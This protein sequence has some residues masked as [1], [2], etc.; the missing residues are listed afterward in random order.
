MKK[1]RLQQNELKRVDVKLFG[2]QSIHTTANIN[3]GIKHCLLQNKLKKNITRN[4]KEQRQVVIKAT[5][6][7]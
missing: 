1:T 2:S 3:T 4:H 7:N 6:S 5:K